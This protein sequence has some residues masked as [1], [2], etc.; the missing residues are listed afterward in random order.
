[1]SDRTVVESG[2]P[3]AVPSLSA[4]ILCYRAE[5][6]LTPYLD[7]LYDE[8]VA[9]GS[10]FELV[11]VANYHAGSDDRTP[12]I[13][14]H[15]AESHPNVRAVARVMVG[16]LGW[17]MH[18]GFAESRGEIII[19][20]DGDGENAPGDVLRMYRQ[21]RTEHVDVAK[22]TRVIR[23]DSV[24]RRLVSSTYN[25]LFKLLFWTWDLG[26]ING[27]PKGLT[28]AALDR[29]DLRS[30]DWFADAE[31][32]LEARRGGFTITELPVEYHRKSERRSFVRP[33]AILEFVINM[34]KHRFGMR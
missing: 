32:V 14:T 24:Y 11:L 12:D 29:L 15:Y 4:I 1:V 31:I 25:L 7:V 16:G 22:G 3:A 10:T 34:L 18:V 23:E 21:M 6:A 28:R 30:D 2:E 27:K 33:T 26:D 5:E 13:A 8:L 17:D 19:V 9:S 20:I